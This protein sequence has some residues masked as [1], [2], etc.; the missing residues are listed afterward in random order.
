LKVIWVH[1]VPKEKNGVK[2]SLILRFT[3]ELTAAKSIFGEEW[4]FLKDNCH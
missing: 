1:V 2:V 4:Y 3:F